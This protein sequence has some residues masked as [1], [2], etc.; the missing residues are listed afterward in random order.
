MGKQRATEY[1]VS[2]AGKILTDSWDKPLDQT[3][4]EESPQRSSGVLRDSQDLVFC[5]NSWGL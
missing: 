3:A 1:I 2:R 5:P 4:N